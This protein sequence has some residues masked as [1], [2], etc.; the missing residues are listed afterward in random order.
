MLGR[1]VPSDTVRHCTRRCKTPASTGTRPLR[2][3][4]DVQRSPRNAVVSA[5]EDAAM[6]LPWLGLRA[7]LSH[8]SGCSARKPITRRWVFN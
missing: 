6:K 1:G 5:G 8:G 4:I 2:S 3:E 7:T